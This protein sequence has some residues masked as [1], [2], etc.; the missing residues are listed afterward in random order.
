MISDRAALHN[1]DLLSIG[2]NSWVA[3]FVSISGKVSIGRNVKIAIGCN[4]AGGSK[5]ISIGNFSGL[6][7]GV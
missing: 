5:G 2:D 1:V 6:A 7:Y 3:D 4:I